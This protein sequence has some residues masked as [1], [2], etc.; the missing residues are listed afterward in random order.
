M[1][2]SA[3]ILF[4][5]TAFFALR[6]FFK[7]F[8]RSLSRTLSFLGAYAAAFY[9]ANPVSVLAKQYLK[10]DGMLAYVLSG[11]AIFILVATLIRLVFWLIIRLSP[12]DPDHIST[13]S[14][15]AG[16]VIG[17][18]AGV[19]I[20]LL[21]VYTWSVYQDA[22]RADNPVPVAQT[23]ADKA[24]RTFVSKTA[25][26]I[27][28]L[29]TD[30]QTTVKM[31]ESFIADPVL[32]VN[33]I[34]RI[35]DNSDLQALLA[36]ERSQRL[37]RSGDIDSLMQIPEFNRLM[38]NTDMKELLAASGID[39]SRQ[40]SAR[41]T[42]RKIALAWQ[43]IQ[44]MQD[45][46]RVE[47][48]INDP[49]FQQQLQAKNKLP[50][51]MNPQLNTLAEIIFVEGASKIQAVQQD[52]STRIQEV[53]PGEGANLEEQGTIYRWVDEQGQVQYSDKPPAQR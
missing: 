33:R 4:A 6:G 20:A 28:S 26:G 32:S 8:L 36:D 40:D 41:Q 16:L 31:S 49:A 25:A 18:L 21:L 44:L 27:L 48:I 2:I 10:L 7:G 46:P 11:L 43:Q 37:M 15:L 39:I 14:R 17:A 34:H 47:A 51:L 24:A 53:Q 13:A 45:D 35:L 5:V 12:H 52:S 29:T 22:R 42:A 3:F 19:V 9:F 23:P 30:N 38:N 1:G 50:L